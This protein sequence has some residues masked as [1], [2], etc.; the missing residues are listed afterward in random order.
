M[1]RSME[2][3]DSLDLVQ[4][5][6]KQQEEGSSG[7][8]G[9]EIQTLVGPADLHLDKGPCYLI[10][11]QRPEELCLFPFTDSASNKKTPLPSSVR[12]VK[13]LTTALLFLRSGIPKATKMRSANICSGEKMQLLGLGEKASVPRLTGQTGLSPARVR[14]PIL[15]PFYS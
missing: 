7:I 12:N 13:N 2:T 11:N 5:N 1:V 10:Q 14:T 3:I 8:R 15:P 6:P 9:P 4:L